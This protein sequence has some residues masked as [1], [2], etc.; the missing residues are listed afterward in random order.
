M[1]NIPQISEPIIENI[2]TGLV[3]NNTTMLNDSA[4]LLLKIQELEAMNQNLNTLIIV[5]S[6]VAGVIAII[7]FYFLWKYKL[8]VY[9]LQ[10]KG[11]CWVH[12][13]NAN[14]ME[15][16]FLKNS[17]YYRIK[18]GLYISDSVADVLESDTGLRHKFFFSNSPY[19][20]IFIPAGVKISAP[21]DA[22]EHLKKK[23][24]SLAP[25]VLHIK[26]PYSSRVL[27]E[28]VYKAAFFGK[29]LETMGAGF[30]FSKEMALVILVTAIAI[31]M[32]LQYLF[33][34]GL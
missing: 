25:K 17:P 18:D 15:T 8:R 20:L 4:S 12:L 3:Q 16:Y 28:L 27:D 32:I 29:R 33:K 6:I 30:K 31:L 2:T 14:S 34:G 19:Q 26:S 1:E 5:L 21:A 11:Y 23:F 13:I 10:K 9:M 24:E 22:P 7:G